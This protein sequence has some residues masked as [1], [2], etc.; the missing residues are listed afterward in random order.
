MKKNTLLLLL[1][2]SFCQLQAQS[3]ISAADFSILNNTSWQGT[4]TYIDGQ[5]GNP[6]DIATTMQIKTDKNII[7][8]D[9]QYVWEPDKN[10]HAS[11]RIRK[12]GRFLGKQKVIS[13]NYQDGDTIEI[14]T[15]ASGK[16][17]GTKAEFQ[18]TY[19]FGPDHYV[20]T[21]NARLEGSQSF[22]L[23]NT[24]RYTRIY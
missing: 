20:V 2:M 18:Y 8:Q 23:S 9:I 15:S 3:R 1:L 22:Q 7:I 19:N 13:I 5:T 16:E 17:H 12:G 11:T 21:K 14:V 6:T 24:Y 10:V 4:L